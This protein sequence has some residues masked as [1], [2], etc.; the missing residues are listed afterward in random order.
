MH[1]CN[2]VLIKLPNF[3]FI[4]VWRFTLFCPLGG[5][6]YQRSTFGNLPCSEPTALVWCMLFFT[7]RS[8]AAVYTFQM[9]IFHQ[10]KTVTKKSRKCKK[11][12]IKN[13]LFLYY[14]QAKCND[15]ANK[16]PN[17][18]DDNEQTFNY[19]WPDVPL[20]KSSP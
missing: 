20:T 5:D 15:I 10:N 2:Y 16:N 4:I 12:S 19:R 8:I 6:L 11:Q 17:V 14:I 9:Q 7:N 18:A 13:F 1:W 3:V